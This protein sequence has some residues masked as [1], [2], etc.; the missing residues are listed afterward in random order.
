LVLATGLSNTGVLK[1]EPTEQIELEFLPFDEAVRRAFASELADAPSTLALL[2]ADH[3]LRS[4][5]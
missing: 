5:R 4:R 1:R 3:K 2:L